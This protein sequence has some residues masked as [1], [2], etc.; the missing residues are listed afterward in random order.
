MSDPPTV[1][2]MS[3]PAGATSRRRAVYAVGVVTLVDGGYV[4]NWQPRK[5][6][7]ENPKRIGAS[8]LSAHVIDWI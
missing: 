8:W 4:G 3:L 7:I 1:L 2:P 5:P 6:T